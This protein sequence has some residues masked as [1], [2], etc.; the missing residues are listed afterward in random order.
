MVL[1]G[2]AGALPAS[3][4]LRV[5]PDNPRWL[6]EDGG[7]TAI[8]L[9][10]AHTWSVFQD[11]LPEGDF[12]AV[13]YLDGIAAEAHNFT[14][15]WFWEDGFYTPLPYVEEGGE[16]RLS[17]PYNRDYAAR[18]RS[19]VRSARKRGLYVSVM[20]FQGW[21]MGDYEGRRVP[22]PW[23]ENPYNRENHREQVSKQQAALHIGLAQPQ[24]LEYV[25][26]IAGKL[27]SEPNVIWEVSNES[28][29][30]SLGNEQASNWQANI[31]THLKGECRRR[32]TWVS[33]PAGGDIEDEF[34]V[35][36]NDRLFAMDADLVS[37]C[38]PAR[39]YS[40][41]PPPADGRRVLVADTDHLVRDGLDGAWV[42]KAF[43][44]GQHP[45]FMDLTQDLSWWEGPPWDPAEPRW[46][47]M[48]AA[49]GSI[50]EL[51]TVVN[52]TRAVAPASGLAAMAPQKGAGGQPNARTKPASAPWALY[53]SD[54]PCKRKSETARCR[55]ARANGDEL[56]A[57][58]AADET[59][60]VCRLAAGGTY[61][62]RWKRPFRTGWA[63]PSSTLVADS[64]GCLEIAAPA[65]E[66]GVAHL[67][68]QL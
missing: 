51:V 13:D 46:G 1:I 41:D 12:D 9:T 66:P 57:W 7:K 38:D 56:L 26:W 64:A 60:R 62:A 28:H 45:V 21:S 44:R 55:Q 31:L 25:S 49:L 2:A 65:G 14:R 23:P 18:L 29:N 5:H 58:A 50:Q 42:W 17:P 4:A 19:R 20:L 43:L 22:N 15:G 39:R 27:C 63:G 52:R 36:L 33:C 3:A 10:G 68:R 59:L 37:P 24:Q 32:L 61:R 54:R 40:T 53:S 11:H 30:A 8:V 48:R 16:Y 6:T 47:E 34:R 67:E 35:D